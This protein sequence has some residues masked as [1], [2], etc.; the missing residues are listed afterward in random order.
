MKLRKYTGW[1]FKK[2]YNNKIFFM[3]F[4]NIFS[5][6]KILVGYEQNVRIFVYC[7]CTKGQWYL[8]FTVRQTV[9]VEVS[10]EK[11]KNWHLPNLRIT[12]NMRR[13]F[14]G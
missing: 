5:C 6:G 13:Y 1:I 7:A 8:K 10:I 12:T 3:W 11:L 4:L 14:Y 9:Y 2:K